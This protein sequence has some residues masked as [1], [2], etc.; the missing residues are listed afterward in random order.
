MH[1]NSRRD[2]ERIAKKFVAVIVEWSVE[3]GLELSKDKTEMIVHKEAGMGIQPAKQLGTKG[4]KKKTKVG[5]VKGSL[6]ITGKG[7]RRPPTIK[8]RVKSIKY[9]DSVNY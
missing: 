7:E 6:V 3:E 9:A 8:M 2:L 1:G 5:S 4:Y